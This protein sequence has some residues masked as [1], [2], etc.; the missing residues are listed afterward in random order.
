MGLKATIQ[1]AVQSAFIAFGDIRTS[2]SYIS[3]GTATY[4]PTTGAV[5]STDVTITIS[6]IL[7]DYEINE[8]DNEA[9]ILT[10][11][12]I[13]I[14]TADLSVTPKIED[15]ITISSITWQV[16]NVGVDPADAM[17][18]LQLRKA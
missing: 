6:G 11:R 8:I 13:M 12:K 7:A 5:T 9:I 17:W 3:K 10:D 16:I 18:T 1:S 14:P 4:N 15:T 2:V